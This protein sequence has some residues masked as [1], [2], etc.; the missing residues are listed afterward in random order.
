[1]I[2]ELY[3]K[4]KEE[5]KLLPY[6]SAS[7][8]S[9]LDT[10]QELRIVMP[11]G[12][13]IPTMAKIGNFLAVTIDNIENNSNSITIAG[14]AINANSLENEQYSDLIGNS[15][16]EVCSL[17]E[18]KAGISII[19]ADST[20]IESAGLLDSTAIATVSTIAQILKASSIYIDS[21]LEKDRIR[22]GTPWVGGEQAYVM[23]WSEAIN[24]KTYDACLC[25]K[26]A[27]IAERVKMVLAEKKPKTNNLYNE[28]NPPSL[29]LSDSKTPSDW[30]A[31][32]LNEV[33][34]SNYPD[35]W[36]NKGQLAYYGKASRTVRSLLKPVSPEYKFDLKYSWQIPAPTESNPAQKIT[37]VVQFV[38]SSIMI[39]ST[40]YIYGAP[41][42][43][44]FQS[45]PIQKYNLPESLYIGSI[46]HSSDTNTPPDVS[47]LSNLIK[48]QGTKITTKEEEK[49]KFYAK[50]EEIHLS[51]EH[52]YFLQFV[53]NSTSIV[54]NNLQMF[55]SNMDVNESSIYLNNFKE[56]YNLAINYEVKNFNLP[57]ESNKINVGNACPYWYLLAKIEAVNGAFINSQNEFEINKNYTVEI[58]DDFNPNAFYYENDERLKY[59]GPYKDQTEQK[60]FRGTENTTNRVCTWQN[61]PEFKGGYTYDELTLLNATFGS[62]IIAQGMFG[63]QI[64]DLSSSN[65]TTSLTPAQ[66]STPKI[67]KAITPQ[68]ETYEWGSIGVNTLAI[69]SPLWKH[70]EQRTAQELLDFANLK[71]GTRTLKYKCYIP[72]GWEWD[73]LFKVEINGLRPVEMVV[74][75]ELNTVEYTLKAK[76]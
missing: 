24:K 5:W 52:K 21:T 25:T 74:Y 31:I 10:S 8:S 63:S 30:E 49:A 15:I 22:I 38:G 58:N 45:D 55:T 60:R 48:T 46:N 4:Y 41:V 6:I 42:L 71:N 28:E 43:D 17:L 61:L 64:I 9:G 70:R 29:L 56:A 12:S 26:T 39:E 53:P 54:I 57:P 47:T 65:I 32:K 14:H 73:D 50:I 34:S 1:M 40:G 67:V 36:S 11:V 72:E 35:Y 51:N 2:A 7:Y 19:G 76:E 68:A 37:K 20:P 16:A 44:E 18:D 59:N 62:S 66:G 33:V 27:P 23:E 13:D 69:S 3:G 75:F